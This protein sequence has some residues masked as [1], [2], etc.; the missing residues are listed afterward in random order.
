MTLN[1]YL[2][3][4]LHTHT[5]TDDDSTQIFHIGIEKKMHFWVHYIEIHKICF[6]I[7]S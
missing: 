3:E 4:K 7:Y 5:H 6:L 1:I 2:T